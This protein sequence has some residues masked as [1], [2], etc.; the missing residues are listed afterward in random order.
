MLQFSVYARFVPSEE[1]AVAH[2]RT[3]R[4]AIPSAGQV[5]IFAITD[6]QFARQEV[7]YG[8]KPRNPEATPQQIMLFQ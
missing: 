7:F 2:R 6:Q 4:N 8:K 3:I 5:R 1:A